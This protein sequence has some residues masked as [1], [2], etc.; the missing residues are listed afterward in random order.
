MHIYDI[1]FVDTIPPSLIDPNAS[2]SV[3]PRT[4]GVNRCSAPDTCTTSGPDKCENCGAGTHWSCCG[5]TGPKSMC[6]ERISQEQAQR[7][8]DAFR[9]RSN[10]N[11]RGKDIPGMVFPGVFVI[12]WRCS[13]CSMLNPLGEKS[14]AGCEQ[15]TGPDPIIAA[16]APKVKTGKGRA[17]KVKAGKGGGAAFAF[18]GG[19]AAAAEDDDNDDDDGKLPLKLFRL[20]MTF[21]RLE[22]EAPRA[23]KA[24]AGPSLA[25]IAEAAAANLSAVGFGGM[26]F[27]G[28]TQDKK[29]DDDE[30]DDEDEDED[31]DDEDSEYDSDN[32]SDM[33]RRN[34]S[35][36]SSAVAS[37]VKKRFKLEE[38]LETD[39]NNE[40][41]DRRFNE[42]KPCLRESSVTSL[43]DD[44]GFSLA[45]QNS[46]VFDS[47][48]AYEGIV[49]IDYLVLSK[50]KAGNTAAHHAAFIGLPR[51]MKALLNYAKNPPL[52]KSKW[53][54]NLAKIV[55][56][57]FSS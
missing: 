20:A 57:G 6:D 25:E 9:N 50:D 26:T 5:M 28:F 47:I 53:V 14:C 10:N 48:K 44:S 32:S 22:A 11:Q 15:D 40:I 45:R 21:S 12:D 1:Y 55:P 29:K 41:L 54:M 49:D 13:V 18:A 31:E 43:E 24:G 19:G 23:E 39:L 56:E 35:S 30:D 2:P 4:E 8:A 16:A 7:N 3:S 37:N 46:G 36:D 51:T 27:K 42:P 33:L 34:T 38:Q 17:P 52:A